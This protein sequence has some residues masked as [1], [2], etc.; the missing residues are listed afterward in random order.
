MGRAERVNILSERACERSL[1]SYEEMQMN[2][3][4]VD[5]PEEESKRVERKG[6]DH[7]ES[8]PEDLPESPQGNE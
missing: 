4:F 6:N 3:K 7:G 2:I 5:P 1:P 8:E